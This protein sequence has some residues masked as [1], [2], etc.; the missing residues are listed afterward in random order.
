MEKFL[1]RN[2][3]RIWQ[4]LQCCDQP[5]HDRCCGSREP[6]CSCCNR[7]LLSIDLIRIQQRFSS[8][9]NERVYNHSNSQCFRFGYP[10][11]VTYSL[12]NSG[13]WETLPDGSK[14]WRLGISSPGALSINLT[15]N[16]FWLPDGAEFYI[17]NPQKTYLL[18]AYSSLNNK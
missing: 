2:K 15:Y 18:G 7:T 17:Y 8:R 5:T 13:T 14:L 6:S 1:F 11:F 10:N 16:D 12:T 4:L 3:I 9:N